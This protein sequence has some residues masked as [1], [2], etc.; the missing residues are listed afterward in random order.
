[1]GKRTPMFQRHLEAHDVIRCLQRHRARFTTTASFVC[2]DPGGWLHCDPPCIYDVW[3]LLVLES[4]MCA[5]AGKLKFLSIP[6]MAH[7]QEKLGAVCLLKIV[8]LASPLPSGSFYLVYLKLTANLKIL[9][10]QGEETQD[11]RKNRERKKTMRRFSTCNISSPP[12]LEFW[13]SKYKLASSHLADLQSFGERYFFLYFFFLALSSSR[14]FSVEKHFSREE[15]VQHPLCRTAT[16]RLL[17]LLP[18]CPTFRDEIPSL[19]W[20]DVA[21]GLSR[22]EINVARFW[23][24]VLEVSSVCFNQR[25]LA[26]RRCLAQ[27]I[28]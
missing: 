24:S 15:Q 18:N 9:H 16:T 26:S 19:L 8:F 13:R 7:R 28:Y 12:R 1:M 4:V 23:R 21:G 10:R 14:V 25:E 27:R 5:I 3:L 2:A 20:W 17:K 11:W 6:S 22:H